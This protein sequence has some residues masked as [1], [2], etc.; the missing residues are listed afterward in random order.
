MNKTLDPLWDCV[1]CQHD[2][3]D[4]VTTWE[5]LP[6]QP[7]GTNPYHKGRCLVVGCPCPGFQNG[8]HL[9]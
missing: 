9:S 8:R 7:P 5:V 1:E 6:P 3:E 4:H 2:Q